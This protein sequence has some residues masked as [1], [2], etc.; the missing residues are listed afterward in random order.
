MMLSF[1]IAILIG[2]SPAAASENIN[3]QEVAKEEQALVGKSHQIKVLGT[4]PKVER[5]VKFVARESHGSISL[6]L[7]R[8]FDKLFLKYCALTYYD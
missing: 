4:P 8:S 7:I 2:F 3:E 5:F 6:G 1:L